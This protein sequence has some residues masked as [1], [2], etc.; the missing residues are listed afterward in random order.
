MLWL[1]DPKQNLR[2]IAAPDLQGHGFVGCGSMLNYR[3][4]ERIARFICATLPELPFTGA[5]AL[6]G[7]GVCQ[8][9][10]PS[11]CSSSVHMV[12]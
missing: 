4:P 12:P 9:A 8:P 6:P 1:E 3:S 11:L 2:G 5:N 7:L 10:A